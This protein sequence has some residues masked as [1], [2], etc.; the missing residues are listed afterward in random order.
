MANF[1]IESGTGKQ[2][3]DPSQFGAGKS[4]IESGTGNTLWGPAATA[5]P[6]SQPTLPQPNSTAPSNL[7]NGYSNPISSAGGGATYGAPNPLPGQLQQGINPPTQ[8]YGAPSSTPTS[9]SSAGNSGNSGSSGYG[10]LTLSQF[11]QQMGIPVTGTQDSRTRRAMASVGVS[12]FAADTPP[13]AT[14]GSQGGSSSF[15]TQQLQPG[16]SGD[17]VKALQDY[18]VSQGMMTQAQVNTGYGIYGPQTTAAV[19]AL[20]QKLGVDNSSGPGYYGP[21]TLAALQAAM[22][23]Q[24]GGGTPPPTQG[25]GSYP[26]DPGA[27]GAAGGAG[28]PNS[29]QPTTGSDAYFQQLLQSMQPDQNQLDL[30]KQLGDITSKQATI[31]AGRDLGIQGVNEQP[32]ATPFLTGEAAAITNRAAVQSN[33]LS[34]QAVPLQQQLALAQSRKQAAIDISKEALSYSENQQSL[35]K[36]VFGGYGTTGYALNPQTGKYEALPGQNSPGADLIS[37]A[38]TDGRLDPSQISRYNLPSIT[39]ALQSDPKHNF[40]GNKVAFTQAQTN[41]TQWHQAADGTWF[42]TSSKPGANSTGSGGTPSTGTG[43]GGGGGGNIPTTG[44]PKATNAAITDQLKQQADVT[45]AISAADTNF[46]LLTDT[47]KGKVNDFNSP[48]ANQV[49]NLLQNRVLGNSDVINFQSAVS[50]LQ[51]EYAAVLGRGGDVTDAVRKSA[52]NVVNGN[53]SMNDLIALHDYIAKEG[54]NVIGAYDKVIN[55]L[56]TS[57][58]ASGNSSSSGGSNPLNI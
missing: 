14:G 52:Q 25:G 4:Y 33:A 13:P 27:A 7:G 43:S 47:F 40:T 17:Q 32:I 10:S 37:Q 9:T 12:S 5:Q 42:A 24:Q 16:A 22:Q 58:T 2:V 26:G 34:A 19:Q 38:I 6:S 57:G 53:Y 50:T 21:Q 46:K 31:N 20:Q 30:Q 56:K 8:S 39:A 11:Q 49:N 36:P 28:V 15:P 18:L 44:T 29:T 23:G 54:A 35:A 55:N 51:T 48:L 41:S 45:R 3:T 1:Y